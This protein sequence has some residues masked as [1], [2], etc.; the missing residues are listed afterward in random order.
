VDDDQPSNIDSTM[1]Q[2]MGGIEAMRKPK[3]KLARNPNPTCHE[4]SML[5]PQKRTRVRQGAWLADDS[6]YRGNM[7]ITAIKRLSRWKC[8]IGTLLIWKG[9]GGY[10]SVAIQGTECAGTITMMVRWHRRFPSP[11]STGRDGCQKKASTAALARHR[12]SETPIVQAIPFRDGRR[13]AMH[14]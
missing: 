14:E 9:H 4:S 10:E 2:C 1:Q 7:A 8:K 11:R 6:A 5:P 3:A 13:L 12:S